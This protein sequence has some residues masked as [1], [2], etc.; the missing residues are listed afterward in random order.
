[1]PNAVQAF[2]K[3]LPP[4][5][6]GEILG[7]AQGIRQ[8]HNSFSPPESYLTEEKAKK[9]TE[10]DDVYHF[11]SYIHKGGA[12][13]ELDGLQKGPIRCAECRQVWVALR[14]W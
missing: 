9:A 3:D 4:D 14:L 13:W 11:V 10:D 7:S 1:V 6:R 8:A 5:M 12:I 2:T